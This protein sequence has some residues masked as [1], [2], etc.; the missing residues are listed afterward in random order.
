MSVHT[1]ATINYSTPETAMTAIIAIAIAIL[2]GLGAVA[3]GQMA[4]QPVRIPVKVRD[5]R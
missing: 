5:D 3:A 1:V 2:A 4:D